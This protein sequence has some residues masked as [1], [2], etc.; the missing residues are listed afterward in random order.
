MGLTEQ[1]LFELIHKIIKLKKYPFRKRHINNCKPRTLA[2][3]SRENSRNDIPRQYIE[4]G[5]H[6]TVRNQL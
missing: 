3:R 4:I 1:P 5:T 6:P 2:R